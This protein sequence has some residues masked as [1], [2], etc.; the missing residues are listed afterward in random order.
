M[1]ELADTGAFTLEDGT[2]STGKKR[3]V[4]MMKHEKDEIN[5]KHKISEK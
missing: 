5:E 4:P 2:I 1:K 3:K